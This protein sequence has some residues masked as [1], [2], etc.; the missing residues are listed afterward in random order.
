MK[1]IIIS[2]A[3]ATLLTAC[4]A[5][6]NAQNAGDISGEWNTIEVNGKKINAEAVE[7]QPF[8]GFSA[9][10]GNLYGNLSCN[11]LTGTYKADV[12]SG[13]LK[14]GSM[15]STMMLCAD[16]STEQQM[17]E[18]LKAVSKYSVDA[19]GQLLLQTKAGKTVM[20]LQKRK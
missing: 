3:A 9:S 5:T 1:N 11:S 18:A 20:T 19:N 7:S 8:I 2:L 17:L 16:M 12:K 14:F 10:D 6:N 4:A 15:G 13:S